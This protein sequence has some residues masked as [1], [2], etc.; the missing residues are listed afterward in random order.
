MRLNINSPLA[1]CELPESGQLSP[2]Q[3]IGIVTDLAICHSDYDALSV[4]SAITRLTPALETGRAKVFFDDNSRPYGYASWTL[5]TDE[6]HHRMLTG[7]ETSFVDAD[8]FF[9]FTQGTNLWFLD[10]L[11]PF[12]SP[13]VMYR[14]LSKELGEFGSAYLTQPTRDGHNT[15]RRVW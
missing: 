11:C 14:M 10:L 7:W 8:Q 1:P 12:S 2:Y 15:V 5:L 9:K 4:D 6:T 3:A 13:I